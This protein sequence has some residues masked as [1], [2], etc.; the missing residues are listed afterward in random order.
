MAVFFQGATSQ[1]RCFFRSGPDRLTGSILASRSLAAAVCLSVRPFVRARARG[2][3]MVLL[4]CRTERSSTKLRH[5]RPDSAQRASLTPFG[6]P[7]AP[8]GKERNETPSPPTGSWPDPCTAVR[9]TSERSQKLAPPASG[10]VFSMFR[11]QKML[12]IAKKCVFG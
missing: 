7:R 8:A 12:K 6:T 10:G 11:V 5:E 1:W 2:L 3:D 9:S 4:E